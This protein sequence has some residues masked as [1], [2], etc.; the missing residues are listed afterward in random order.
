V[1][2][3]GA[4]ERTLRRHAMLAGGETVLVA[5]SGGADSVALLHGLVALAPRWRLGLH[6]LH[7]DH[8]LRPD[9]ARDAEF[10]HGLGARLGVPVEV[11]TVAVAPRDSLE[12]AAR[13]ARYA[14]LEACADR[15]GAGRI[16]VGHTADDQ[17]ET[18]LMRLLEGTGVRGLAGIPPVRGRVIRPLLECRRAA[19]EAELRRAGL[20]WVED[21]SNRDPKFLRNRVRHELLPFLAGSYNPEIADALARVAALARETVSAL[22]RVAAA[23]LER[24]AVPGDEAVTLPLAELRALPRPVAAEVLRQAAA[25]LGSKAPVR[26]WAHRGLRRVLAEPAPRR[27]FRL[28]GVA[29]EV[30]GPRVRLGRGAP[31]GLGERTLAVPGRL[32]LPEIGRV[33][34]ATLAGTERYAIPDEGNRAAFD[35]DELPETLVVRARRPGDRLEPFGGGARTLKDLLIDAK[36][37]RWERGRVPVIE[38]AGQ[39]L[40]V[41]GVRRGAAAPLTARTR[42]VLELALLPLVRPRAGL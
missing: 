2:F 13:Q 6:V 36:V 22:D 42:R 16:A 9:S 19:L 14:A 41:A 3:L 26:A 40:W 4:V 24:L 23:A 5:V 21:P 39:I 34:E 20:D 33:L 35:A 7:V 12:A 11:A 10:V 15:V 18:V 30:S 29:L 1:T 38:A 27:P 32:E 8:G 28:G 31:P 17:A 25:R 37:P